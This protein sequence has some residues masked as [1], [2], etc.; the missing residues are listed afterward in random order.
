MISC[1]WA[2]KIVLL[3]MSTSS[4]KKNPLDSKP[5]LFT[6]MEAKDFKLNEISEIWAVVQTKCAEPIKEE[7]HPWFRRF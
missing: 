4:D 3:P 5:L 7:I 1:G 6:V 2:K